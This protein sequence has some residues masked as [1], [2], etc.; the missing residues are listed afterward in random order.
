MYYKGNWIDSNYSGPGTI[1]TEFDAISN[2]LIHYGIGKY[3]H[4]IIVDN[5]MYHVVE[6]NSLRQAYKLL[7]TGLAQE[8]ERRANGLGAWTW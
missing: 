6:V 7:S 5:T 8:M 4:S 2:M 3:L 1:H